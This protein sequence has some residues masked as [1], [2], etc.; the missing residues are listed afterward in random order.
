MQHDSERIDLNLQHSRDIPD[1]YVQA[2]NRSAGG[3]IRV[4]SAECWSLTTASPAGSDKVVLVRTQRRMKLT[5]LFSVLQGSSTPS[6]TWDIKYGPDI[7]GTGAT[8]IA[9]SQMTTSTTTGNSHGL[10]VTFVPA[11]QYVWIDIASV[12][13]TVGFFNVTLGC[14]PY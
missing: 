7:S 2:W 10:S 8:S 6:V 12:S 13:G 3:D 4:S 11:G 14:Y 9:T 5:E 1:G